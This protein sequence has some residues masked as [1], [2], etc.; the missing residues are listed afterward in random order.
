VDPLSPADVE[1]AR[2]RDQKINDHDSSGDG[3]AGTCPE[4]DQQAALMRT[5]RDGL[6]LRNHSR[7]RDGEQFCPGT[8]QPPAARQRKAQP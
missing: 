6:V 5:M 8:G 4:C 3:G 1:G 7:G 2:A